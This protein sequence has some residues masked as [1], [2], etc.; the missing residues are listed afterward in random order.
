MVC[1]CDGLPRTYRQSAVVSRHEAASL[2]LVDAIGR[3]IR[4]MLP[5]Y[6]TAPTSMQKFPVGRVRRTRGV[7]D[8]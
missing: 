2:V 1:G 7:L 5:N 4:Q 6:P 3:N 8:D